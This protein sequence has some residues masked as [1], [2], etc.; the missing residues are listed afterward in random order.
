MFSNRDIVWWIQ[1][2]FSVGALIFSVYLMILM[3]ISFRTCE[4]CRKHDK[5]VDSSYGYAGMTYCKS[6]A[7]KE[8]Y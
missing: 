5:K 3:E 7:I 4:K 2:N 1:L 8:G 6:C